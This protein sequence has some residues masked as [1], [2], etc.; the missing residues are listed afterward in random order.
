M[1]SV[2]ET[3]DCSRRCERALAGCA[4]IIRWAAGQI[5]ESLPV[6]APFRVGVPA[7]RPRH[8]TD[9]LDQRP[10]RVPRACSRPSQPECHGGH[11]RGQREPDRG[12][13]PTRRPPQRRGCEVN[14]SAHP[15]RREREVHRSVETS[16]LRWDVADIGWLVESGD[17]IPPTIA[18]P[19]RRSADDAYARARVTAG[20]RRI[21]AAN[22]PSFPRCVIRARRQRRGRVMCHFAVT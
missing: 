11:Q 3:G 7:R 15:L 6:P 4:C 2:R 14:L 18:R 17:G 8:H 9:L 22:L 20:R 13:H 5:R 1:C 12:A 16:T 21:T 19:D 10:T